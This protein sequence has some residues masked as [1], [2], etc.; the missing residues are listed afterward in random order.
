MR[1]ESVSEKADRTG[2]YYVKLSD[3]STLRLYPQT[4]TDFKLLP[5]RV[6]EADTLQEIRQA[7]GAISAKMRAVRIVSATAV[8][9]GDL[10]RR[11][12]NKGETP[13]DA[14]SAVAWMEELHLLDDLDTAK[15]LVRRGLA[16]GYGENRLRQMLYEKRIP[17]ELWEEALADLPEPDEAI[18]R[19]LAQ[20]LPPDAGP[21]EQKKVIDALIRRGYAWGDIRR[22]L[23]RRGE[24]IEGEPE[25]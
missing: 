12:R 6:L 25:E 20:K 9:A 16:K 2:Q 11:L 22:A 24:S 14:R 3:G 13:E 18:A 8:A 15:Q 4:I 7:A 19:F 10:E 21:K 23:N 1:I 17:K 5:G